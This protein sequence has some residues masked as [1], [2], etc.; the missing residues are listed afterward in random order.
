MQ[1]RVG[2]PIDGVYGICMIYYDGLVAPI[3]SSVSIV[4]FLSIDEGLI[5]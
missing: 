3:I 1:R 4:A 2:R 5:H